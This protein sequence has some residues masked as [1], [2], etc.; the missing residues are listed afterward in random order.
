M[1]YS[2]V[3]P[4][5]RAV[6]AVHL[7]NVRVLDAPRPAHSVNK[8]E[9]LR[10]LATART[11]YGLSDRD[12]TVLQ[13]LIS[14]YPATDLEGAEMIVYPSNA[15]I[16]DRLNGMPCSTMRRHMAHLV[17]AG[18]VVRR[19]SP[20]GKRYVRRAGGDQTAYGFDLSPLAIRFAEFCERAELIRADI[21][22]QSRLRETVSLMRRDLAGLVAYGRESRPDLGLWDQLGDLAI[23]AARAL[24][25]KLGIEDLRAMFG[26]LKTALD[27][28]RTVFD[29]VVSEDM[30]TNN[31]E[32]EQH[33]QN[34]NT[35][36]HDFELREETAKAAGVVQTLSAQEPVEAEIVPS[37]EEAP[38]PRVP[39]GLV[40]ASCT[41]IHSYADGPIRHWHDFVRVVAGVRPMMGISPSAWE[42]AK[43]VMGPEEAAI[44]LAAMLERFAEIKSPGG[45]LRSLTNKAARGEFSSGPMV[46]ALMRRAA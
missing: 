41:E 45:Y 19:D 11:S 24:R 35:Q 21:E 16:C 32:S 9:A 31:A 15:A 36:S 44:V 2:P 14:F 6:D 28:V 30:S 10:E 22:A 1:G 13:A 7:E 17:H 43:S 12:M 40:L 38:L 42:D 27:M 18:I 33:Y 26:E 25:R 5:R 3:T 46:M 39:L 37:T 20:N 8:W 4:F 29:P 23:L 34:S